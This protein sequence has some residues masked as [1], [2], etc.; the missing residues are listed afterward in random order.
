MAK[1]KRDKWESKMRGE[2]W[3]SKTRGEQWESKTRGEKWER[4]RKRRQLQAIITI[5][6]TFYQLL[7]HQLLYVSFKA[8]AFNNEM[9]D[10]R[11]SYLLGHKDDYRIVLFKWQSSH[12]QRHFAR[13]SVVWY[14]L[15]ILYACI[16]RKAIGKLNLPLD[17]LTLRSELVSNQGRAICGDSS[18][19]STLTFDLKHHLKFV[20]GFVKE[21]LEHARFPKP[22]GFVKGSC[23]LL[24]KLLADPTCRIWH[25]GQR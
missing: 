14:R 23:L 11:L 1:T 22:S 24:M 12:H 10:L 3:E 16:H 2:K 18:S 13:Q 5:I 17:C 8:N 4:K 21:L 9:K 6:T 20:L 7:Y 25:V 15:I 19:V